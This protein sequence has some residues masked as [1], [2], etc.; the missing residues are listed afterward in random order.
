MRLAD[1]EFDF[2]DT[3]GRRAFASPAVIGRFR[4]PVA[5]GAEGDNEPAIAMVIHERGNIVKRYRRQPV[6]GRGSWFGAGGMAGSCRSRT[7]T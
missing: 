5:D 1:V 6:H 3:D 4:H 2:G 7:E